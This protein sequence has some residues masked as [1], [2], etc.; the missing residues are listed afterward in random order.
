MVDEKRSN[1]VEEMV[2]A[3]K[4]WQGIE[5]KS[6]A[7]AAETIEKTD[8]AVIRIIMEIIRHDS[9]MHHR[10]QQFIIDSLT[11]EA[12]SLTAEEV[13]EMMERIKEHDELER[14]VIDLAKELKAKAWTPVHK[15]LFDYLLT[16]EGKHERLL[17]QL[18]EL[19]KDMY[20]YGS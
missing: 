11:H 12:V 9:M 15:Q 20:P 10:V 19:K 1:R 18:A 4:H 7:Q 2:G 5:R 3:L 8:N 17:E 6:M 13:G 16:D 14:D